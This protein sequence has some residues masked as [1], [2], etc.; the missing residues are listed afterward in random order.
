MSRRQNTEPKDEAF[1][2]MTRE[3]FINIEYVIAG[4]LSCGVY[5]ADANFVFGTKLYCIGPYPSKDS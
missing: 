2:M 4:Y 1:N 3:R 5:A